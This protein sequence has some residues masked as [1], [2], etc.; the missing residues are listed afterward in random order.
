MKKRFSALMLLL[1]PLLLCARE[2]H[3]LP[4]MQPKLR[5]QEIRVG[6]SGNKYL[7]NTT[8]T[9]SDS[10]SGNSCLT[11]AGRRARSGEGFQY[12]AEGE[13]FYGLG[14]ANLRYLNVGE[15]YA[16]HKAQAWSFFGGR[17]RFAWSALDS[18]W[19]LGLFQ[20]RFRWD[21][22][23]EKENGLLGLFTGYQTEMFSVLVFASPVFIPE[24]GAPFDISSGS[25][26]S[27][28]PWF[29][30]PPS[31]FLLF[32]EP[33]NVS[34]T[35]DIP[36]VR[37]LVFHAGAGATMKVGRDQGAFGR[38]SYAHKPMN[39]L[40]LSFEGP[41]NFS[42]QSVPAI[43]RPRV[44]YHDLAGLDLGWNGD[45]YSVVASGIWEKPHRDGTPVKPTPPSCTDST[46]AYHPSSRPSATLVLS[47]ATSVVT[48]A[49]APTKAPSQ[50][51]TP[52]P[53]SRA[54]PSTMPTAS[55]SLPPWWIPGRAPSFSARSSLPTPSTKAIS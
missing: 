45:R 18:Y 11:L 26:K 3:A 10:R 55:P 7:T 36:P 29:S 1:A 49:T 51:R 2:S 53:S 13:G 12:A 30:C 8:E 27:S 20:P 46:S 42:S 9:I 19:S 5:D 17:K 37:R 22:L 25:C 16:G 43:I 41:I 47:S 28:S 32:N 40:L 14:G 54:T 35:L 31:S 6:I 21:Y 52:P 4:S 38:L 24:Q 15:F 48:A 44:L 39:Q 33:T 34:F 50:T 23:N